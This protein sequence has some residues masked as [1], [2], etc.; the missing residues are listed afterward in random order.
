MTDFPTESVAEFVSLVSLARDDIYDLFGTPVPLDQAVAHTID[1]HARLKFNQER[2][3]VKDELWKIWLEEL[4]DHVVWKWFDGQ[5]LFTDALNKFQTKHRPVLDT[6]LRG[7]DEATLRQITA[8]RIHGYFSM[9]DEYVVSCRVSKQRLQNNKKRAQYLLSELRIAPFVSVPTQTRLIRSLEAF[10]SELENGKSP[11]AF[12]KNHKKA[13]REMFVKAFY[14]DYFSS[15]EAFHADV[16]TRISALI[17]PEITERQV[18]R[19]TEPLRQ[20]S[21]PPNLETLTRE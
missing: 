4:S 9:T 8:T 5:P 19:I 1:E 2:Q 12:S 21:G 10:L 17:D 18:Y 20:T 16:V 14:Y 3:R 13:K 6:S 7:I 15:F 11:F